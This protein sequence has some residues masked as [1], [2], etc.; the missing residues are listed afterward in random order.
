MYLLGAIF[1]SECVCVCVCV[2]KALQLKEKGGKE[3]ATKCRN[4]K[5][6]LD[7]DPNLGR[8]IL[9]VCVLVCV[10]MC[11]LLCCLH[12]FKSVRNGEERLHCIYMF[13][14]LVELD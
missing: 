6:E 8:L 4:G 5:Q 3:E 2:G 7:M 14:H 12:V 11:P 1:F 9:R 13:L 10:C